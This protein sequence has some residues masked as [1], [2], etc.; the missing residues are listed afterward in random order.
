MFQE[1]RSHAGS[2][3]IMAEDPLCVHLDDNHAIL[4]HQ[5]QS[6]LAMFIQIHNHANLVQSW[7]NIIG[8]VHRVE[9]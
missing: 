4:V 8:N 9:D 7:Q 6:D 3:A 2:G 1:V 5:G